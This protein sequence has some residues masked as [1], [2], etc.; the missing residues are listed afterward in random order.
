MCK[1][2]MTNCTEYSLELYNTDVEVDNYRGYTTLTKWNIIESLKNSMY[3]NRIII[4]PEKM[5][6]LLNNYVYNNNLTDD[7]EKNMIH[8]FKTI[9]VHETFIIFENI[10]V[11]KL[12]Y[13]Y[14]ELNNNLIEKNGDTF[15]TKW[16][17]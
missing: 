9:K 3:G 11:D 12:F 15:S 7:Q 16:K 5:T 13:I 17:I 2:I 10:R 8:K 4:D 6:K 1:Y 14:L